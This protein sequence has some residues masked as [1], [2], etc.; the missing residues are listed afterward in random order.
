M[1]PAAFTDALGLAGTPL[2]APGYTVYGIR[3]A[4]GTN[5]VY[6]GITNHVSARE[7][8]HVASGRI[9]DNYSLEGGLQNVFR[10]WYRRF[11]MPVPREGTPTVFFLPSKMA[12]A[13]GRTSPHGASSLA[14]DTGRSGTRPSGSLQPRCLPNGITNSWPTVSS[15]SSR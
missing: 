13:L 10:R 9:D 14:G 7:A 12:V 6:I 2:N 11:Q 5:L 3:P 4:G 8:A 1:N 15:F